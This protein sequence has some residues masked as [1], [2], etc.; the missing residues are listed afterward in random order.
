MNKIILFWVCALSCNAVFTQT[1]DSV[2]NELTEELEQIYKQG[3]INGFSVAI[4]NSDATLFTKGFGFADVKQKK[5]YTANTI[6][7][8]A[9]ISKTFIGVSLLK[10]EELGKLKLDDP[11]NK[12]LSFTVVNPHYPDEPITIKQL[13][14]HTS[15]IKDAKQYEGRG[16]ILKGE[17]NSDAQVNN[18]FRSPNEMMDYS[19][20]LEKILSENG[21]WYKKKNFI[22]KKPGE[23]FE[24]SNIAAGLAALVLQQ[25]VGESFSQFTKTYIFKPLAMSNTSWS[26]E[27]VDDTKN[28]KLYA[29]INTELAPYRLINYPDGGLI[30]SSTDLGKYLSELILGYSGQGKLLS[31]EGYRELFSS[32]LNNV[33][34][35]NRSNSKYNDEY[36]MG[37]FMGRSAKGQF[38]HSG[39]DPAV[40]TLMF[41]NSES[42]TGKLLISNTDL[43]KE[44][45]QEFIAI[46]KALQTFQSKF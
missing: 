45:V 10:A 7:T 46:W 32:N 17:N 42:K 20:F 15:T 35:K 21:E 44:G 4:V 6:Q 40:T 1:D 9:S 12:Y 30:T 22:K 24:Y 14:T 29:D 31:N 39:G 43:S 8:I 38:G 23:I 2:A 11:I 13:A 41:F 26:L 36:D 16:Y 25:A 18:N 19:L 27:E 34:H 33:I 5:K 3:H 28:T 37:I